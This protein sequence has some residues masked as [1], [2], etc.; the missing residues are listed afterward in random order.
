MTLNFARRPFRD[1]RPVYLVA[2]AALLL[3]A[4]LFAINA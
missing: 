1:Y 3:G 2:G 4:V